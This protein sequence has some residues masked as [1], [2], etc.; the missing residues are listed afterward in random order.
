MMK[1]KSIETNDY[2][3]TFY[4]TAETSFCTWRRKI[5][6]IDKKH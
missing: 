5:S 6:K 3:V 1:N 4:Q 2:A